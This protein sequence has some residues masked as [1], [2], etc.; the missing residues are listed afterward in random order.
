MSVGLALII[1]ITALGVALLLAIIRASL[2]PTIF[3]RV[4][5]GNNIGTLAVLAI[6]VHG[7]IAGRPEFLDIALLYALINFIGTIAILRYFRLNKMGD[8]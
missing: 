4:L 8:E 1:A 5:A 3:D 2:G 6:A 7:F